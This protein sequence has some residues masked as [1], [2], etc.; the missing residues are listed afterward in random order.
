MSISTR[1]ESAALVA[2]RSMSVSRRGGVTGRTLIPVSQR[3]DHHAHLGECFG[4]FSIDDLQRFDGASK[5]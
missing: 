1:N 5:G 3:V 2:I 4:G